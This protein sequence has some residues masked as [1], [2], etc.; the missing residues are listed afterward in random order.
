M[1]AAAAVVVTWGGL[2]ALTG[3]LPGSAAGSSLSWGLPGLVVPTAVIDTAQYQD[4]ILAGYA[5]GLIGVV[6][7]LL[8]TVIAVRLLTR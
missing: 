5:L 8:L 2:V 6:Q 7:V 1:V 4:L 3:S